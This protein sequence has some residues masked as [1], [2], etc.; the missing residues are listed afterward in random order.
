MTDDSLCKVCK[1]NKP[2]GGSDVCDD[3]G[4]AIVKK[5]GNSPEVKKAVRAL[6]RKKQAPNN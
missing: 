1:T 6:R 5:A 4:K 3:C 2:S